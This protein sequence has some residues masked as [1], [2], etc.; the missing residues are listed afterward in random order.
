[1]T[2]TQNNRN[3]E[4]E[5]VYLPKG[6]VLVVKYDKNYPKPLILKYCDPKP[7]AIGAHGV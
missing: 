4:E 7:L 5:K 2:E 3:I 1:M 6:G